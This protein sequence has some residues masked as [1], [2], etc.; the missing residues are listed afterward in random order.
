MEGYLRAASQISRLAVGDRTR[1]R[2]SAPTSCRARARRCATSTARRWGRA[3]ASRSSTPSRPTANT[4]SRWRCTRAA[5]GSSAA[6]DGD[7][8]RNEQIE[9]SIDGERAALL[10]LDPR[11]SETDPKNGLTSRRR[12]FTSRPGRS[13]SPPPSSSVRR[14]GRRPGGADRDTLADVQIDASASPRCRTCATSR[15][16]GRQVTG[17]SDTPSRRKMFTCRPTGAG[18]E[19]TVRREIIKRLRRR[20]TAVRRRRRRQDADDVLRRRGARTATSRPASGWRCRRCS[21]AR[22]SCSASSR[23][24]RAARSGRRLPHQRSRARVAPVVLPLGHGARRRADEGGRAGTLR[25]P[26]G[27][28]EAGAPDAGRPRRRRCRPA[29]RAVA[30]AA[31]SRQDLPD[32]LLYPDYDYTLG[33]VDAARDRAVLRQHRARGPQLLDLL[34]ADYT[35]VN[36]RLAKH[37]GIPNVTGT[38]SAG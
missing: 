1:R 26:A 17:V 16:S 15:C 10:D 35:F 7:A 4:C 2:H 9:V 38:S 3:A 25:T 21:P 19:T 27:A 14:A 32:A 20:P 30:A 22:T 34:T 37:Y 5:G 31:G 12:R 24:R 33:A 18:E 29:S 28:R 36:E 6:R 8:G 11:M 13:A 23:R